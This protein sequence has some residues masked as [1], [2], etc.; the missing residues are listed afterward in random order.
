MVVIPGKITDRRRSPGMALGVAIVEL[1]LSNLL[2]DFD[3]ELPCG[4]KREDTDTNVLPGLAMH[5]KEPLCFV[6]RN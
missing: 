3:W 6:P 2:Y 1:V 4:M 5:K